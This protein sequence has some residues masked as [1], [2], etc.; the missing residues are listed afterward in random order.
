VL[1]IGW[2]AILADWCARVI[3]TIKPVVARIAETAE[4]AKPVASMRL[5][6]ISD[7][8]WH[9][10]TALKAKHTQRLDVELVTAAPLSA[11]G[12][13]TVVVGKL[14]NSLLK[15]EQGHRHC[16]RSRR[17]ASCQRCA[18][19]KYKPQ[20]FH[21]TFLLGFCVISRMCCQSPPAA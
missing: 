1:R 14:G 15:H 9:D 11:S 4:R 2:R 10:I 3:R 7:R 19:S 18:Q 6:V 16:L 13:G 20:S 21:Q 5:D 12:A 17:G 8:R